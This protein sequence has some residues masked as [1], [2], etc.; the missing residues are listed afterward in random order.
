MGWASGYIKQLQ[1]GAT[2]QCRPRG[3]SMT[4]KIKSGQ[5][6]TIVPVGDGEGMI[7]PSALKK[8][9]IVLCKVGRAEY[10]HLIGAI[11]GKRFHIYNNHGHRNGDIP[12]DHIFGKLVKVES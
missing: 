7:R 5:L 2:V 6:C 3:N 4:P 9:D 1:S 10:L 11:D 12:A 8:G